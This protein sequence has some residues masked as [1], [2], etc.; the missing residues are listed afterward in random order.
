MDE[1]QKVIEAVKPCR[2][3]KQKRQKLID[4]GFDFVEND[5]TA[6]TDELE[7]EKIA[8]PKT[9]RQKKLI[10]YFE[11]TQEPTSALLE[12]FFF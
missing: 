4:L 10:S 7:E 6:S 2:S 8:K 1:F 5:L 12:D 11:S 3:W 9:S